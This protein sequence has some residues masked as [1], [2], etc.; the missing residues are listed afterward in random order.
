MNPA[1]PASTRAPE[2]NQAGG[3]EPVPNG[4]GGVF[5][6]VCA[7]ET[8]AAQVAPAAIQMPRMVRALRHPDFRLFWTGNL[9][10]NCGTWMQNIALGWLVLELS[11]SAFWLGVVGF[12]ASAPMLV[13]TLLGGVIAD[14]VDRRR[15]MLRT[16][17]AMML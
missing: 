13:F 9:L 8:I 5:Q 14:R 2:Q 6:G 16:Q 4:T 11:N 7:E 17:A 3:D 10:S 12:A 15:L 1:D